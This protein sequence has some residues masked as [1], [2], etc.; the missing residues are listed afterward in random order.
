VSRVRK[1]VNLPPVERHLLVQA[2]LL[3]VAVRLGLWLLPFQT[4]RRLLARAAR[5]GHGAR[6]VPSGRVVWAVKAASRSVPSARTCLVQALAGQVL[7]TRQGYPVQLRI[8]VAKGEEGQ[9]EA[10]AWLESEGRIVI[11][12]EESP[13]RFTP[14]PHHEGERP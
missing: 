10:H 5:G 9:L 3:A 6:T 4:L 1:F 8:G 11:G 12:G 14:F 13:S 7:L 2:V